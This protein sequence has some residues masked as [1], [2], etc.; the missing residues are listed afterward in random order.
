MAK[1]RRKSDIIEASQWH[2]QGDHERVQEMTGAWEPVPGNCEYCNKSYVDHGF[3]ETLTGGQLVCPGD[4][5]ITNSDG[6]HRCRNAIFS[7]IYE[8]SDLQ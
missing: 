6:D 1:Y 8:I 3:V 7:E 2:K 4:W 5:I